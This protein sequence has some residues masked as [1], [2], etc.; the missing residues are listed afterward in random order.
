[1]LKSRWRK[2]RPTWA[3]VPVRGGSSGPGRRKFRPGR[4]FRPSSGQV[5]KLAHFLAVTSR[6]V[7]TDF[8]NLGGTWA[9]VPGGRK[10]RSLGAEV[11]A[12]STSLGAGRHL[13]SIWEESGRKFRSWR[14]EVP[15]CALELH[16]HHFQLS[17]HWLGLHGLCLDRCT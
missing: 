6:G 3:E 5:P 16:L 8:R 1:V 10:F 17:L 7:L 9:E 13:G 2:F 14:A 11:P 15:A 12:G 4:K